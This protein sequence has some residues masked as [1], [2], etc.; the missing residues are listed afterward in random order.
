MSM[1]IDREIVFKFLLFMVFR[2]SRIVLSYILLFLLIYPDC[3]IIEKCNLNLPN[4][5]LGI[6]CILKI[7]F[8]LY[9]VSVSYI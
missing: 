2:S 8:L 7:G 9:K 3:K 6:N 1:N 5:V 4:L